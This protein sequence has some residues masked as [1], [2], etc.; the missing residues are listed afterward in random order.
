MLLYHVYTPMSIKIFKIGQQ[1]FIF[2]K[3][4]LKLSPTK[5]INDYFLD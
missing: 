5:I 4:Y 1:R 3:K 2:L